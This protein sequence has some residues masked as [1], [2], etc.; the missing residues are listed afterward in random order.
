MN[1]TA[2]HPDD[3]QLRRLLAGTLSSGEEAAVLALLER[4]PAWQSALDRLVADETTWRAAAQSLLKPPLAA[5][6]TLRSVLAAWSARSAGG[7]SGEATT[8]AGDTSGHGMSGSVSGESDHELD[9][10]FLARSEN[11]AYLGQ[12][13][14]YLVEAVIG[15]GGFGVVLK[16][17]DPELAR[18]VAIKVLSPHLATSGTACERFK[19]EARAAAAVT[20][21][22]V[23]TIYAVESEP[24]PHLVMQ[25]IA[26]QS[27]EE[28]LDRE[29]PLGIK[30]TL[31]IG[32]QTAAGLAAAHK[33]GLVH[34]DV[35]PANILLENG[36]ERVKLTDF[37]LARAAD[38][39]SLTR[40]GTIAGTPQFMSPEQ[41]RAESVDARSDLFSLGTVLYAMLTGRSPFRAD[42]TLAVLKRVCDDPPRPIREINPDV[43]DWLAVLITRLLAKNPADRP[44]SAQEIADQLGHYL[45]QLQQPGAAAGRES[46][47]QHQARQV[48]SVVPPPAAATPIS[49]DVR[50][51]INRIAYIHLLMMA[52]STI[53][54][55]IAAIVFANTWRGPHNGID[56]TCF[57]IMWV[58]ALSLPIPL[59]TALLTLRRAPYWVLMIG[60]SLTLLTAGL[61]NLFCWPISMGLMIWVLVQ[62]QHD[63]V[64]AALAGRAGNGFGAATKWAISRFRVAAKSDARTATDK[65]PAGLDIDE[66][67]RF[68]QPI[69][70]ALLALAAFQL[71]AIPAIY[72]WLHLIE[73]TRPPPEITATAVML[74]WMLL[75]SASVPVVGGVLAL[76]LAWYRAAVGCAWI[77]LLAALI[78]IPCWPIAVGLAGWSLWWLRKAEA[79][80]A[81]ALA[82]PSRFDSDG[83]LAP[84]WINS[85]VRPVGCALLAIAV[86]CGLGMIGLVG[87]SNIVTAGRAPRAEFF[88]PIIALFWLL[89]ASSIVPLATGILALRRSTHYAVSGG[90]WLSLLPALANIPCWPISAP[91][92]LWVLWQVRRDDVREA[93]ASP[94]ARRPPSSVARQEFDAMLAKPA[95]FDPFA[96]APPTPRRSRLAT[97][98]LGLGLV[99]V[100]LTLLGC[101]S[102]LASSLFHSSGYVWSLQDNTG[103]L[104]VKIPDSRLRAT[105]RLEGVDHPG[106][107]AGAVMQYLN[108]QV[109]VV[110]DT[111]YRLKAG[112]YLL[113]VQSDDAT[114]FSA[115]IR[116]NPDKSAGSVP[117][118]YNVQ[119]GGVLHVEAHSA[120][121]FMSVELNGHEIMHHVQRQSQRMLVVPAGSIRLKSLFGNWVHAEK[122]LEI[123]AGEEKRV[124]VS[125]Q[126]IDEVQ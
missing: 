24:L 113:T 116:I 34:R 55:V 64:R 10:R 29:G 12:L 37:G 2:P 87:F 25:Y 6:A 9:L 76:R 65:L 42:S 14:P 5:D 39:A 75:V 105:L 83:Q 80:E 11:P 117:Q 97:A 38:D 28:K 122:W 69:G 68:V 23:I 120:G 86:L 79:Q 47:V 108:D 54:F 84:R 102:A 58:L 114:V 44:D 46:P 72:G 82:A 35:K 73:S 51:R 91:L 8:T 18:V 77:S 110:S 49:D 30:E 1:P 112:Q 126:S 109:P 93:L 125:Q 115:P 27:L 123:K 78:N 104:V 45:W 4:E 40:S 106:Y 88:I 17:R 43:P 71:A 57:V 100:G 16:A 119:P 63:D 31:R 67:R 92:A 33:Q 21:E 103:R 96:D 20:H 13:G 60:A 50:K 70:F 41:A 56:M 111:V 3:S 90:A 7:N 26:G 62:L 81:F 19:R 61:F 85:Q 15:R 95:K 89:G 99:V 52:L 121:T 74:I 118:T 48:A 101:F 66:A 124:R 59:V 32:M 22:H 98:I 53:G 36:I 94:T 107:S